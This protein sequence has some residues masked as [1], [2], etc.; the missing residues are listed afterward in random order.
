MRNSSWIDLAAAGP[1]RQRVNADVCVVGA[2]AAGIYLSMQLAKRGC[3]VVLIEAG[4]ARCAD[5]STTGFDALC[6]DAPYPGA[7]VG[8]YFGIGG[9]TSRWGGVLVPHTAHDLR[10]G[11]AAADAWTHIVNTV[12]DAAADVLGELGYLSGWDFESFAEQRLGEAGATLRACGINVQAALALPFRR[13]NFVGL[14]GNAKSAQGQPRVFFNAVAK[15]WD[16]DRGQR[17]GARVKKAIAVS[18]NGNELE[19]TAAKFVVAVGAIESARVLFEIDGAGSQP[20]LRR[21]AATG[22][23]LS[24]HLSVPI[25]DVEPEG[26]AEAAATFAPRFAGGWMRGFRLLDGRSAAGSNRAFAHF[27]FLNL[28]R[29]F[30]LAKEVLGAM[31]R[32][33]IPAIRAELAIGG[34]AEVL[35]LAY[36]RAVHSKLHVPAGTA[37]HLQLD[38]EQTALRENRV[39]LADRSDGFGRRLVS[40]RWRISDLDME[41]MTAAA[42]RFLSVWPGGRSGLPR[43]RARSIGAEG[44]KPHD[45]YHPVGTCRMGENS[46]A[47]V[48]HDLKV[49]GM[50]NLWVA[51]TGVLP[52][53]GTANPSFTMLC[54]THR[55][56][57]HLCIAP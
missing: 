11:D 26:R 37:A 14:L 41:R 15:G 54:L 21:T 38:M 22:C 34:T 45:A 12:A 10:E 8:R 42:R 55:L 3:S 39:R 30:D 20:V 25:A 43:L 4:P 57:G 28:G 36:E 32:R 40:I 13:K 51:S 49:W 19:V 23:Y 7:T 33:R 29:G 50:E 5:A 31:Q 1:L 48:D 24:D 9:T 17:G 18:R 16:L 52:S 53:A 47:V 27:I 46:E 2:G 56:A 6:E 35:R 44:T